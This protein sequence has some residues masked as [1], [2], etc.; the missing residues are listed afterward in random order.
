MKLLD[1]NQFVSK[2]NEQKEIEE[3]E[4]F[5][6]NEAFESKTIQKMV[7]N[8][9]G[10]IGKN[11]FDA[12]SK[13]GIAASEIKDSDIESITPDAATKYARANP[14]KL[15]IYYSEKAKDNPYAKD[16]W[17]GKI[18]ADVVLAV[19][20]GKLFMGLNY[21]NWASKK[22]SKAEYVLVA[23]G[24]QALGLSNKGNTTFSSGINTLDKMAAISDVVY[25]IDP[26]K[27]ASSRETRQERKESRQGATFFKDD[28]EFKRENLSRY[29]AIL[30]ERASKDDIDKI[31]KDSI[32]LLNAQ[33]HD[34]M[35][36]KETSEYG[37]LLVGT[38]PK[39]R[40]VKM[41][42]V[43]YHMN[44]ILKNYSDYVRSDNDAKKEKSEMGRD[45]YYASR[46]KE[47]AKEIKDAYNKIKTF[48]YA[49]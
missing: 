9:K 40:Q 25:V 6:I 7:N 17:Y 33:I 14:E 11:F 45:G 12:L 8:K 26:S 42:D 18:K 29:E 37:E 5:V 30:R 28:K 3:F 34:A 19:V 46:A 22:S 31:V 43:G 39:G 1:Y 4:N 47:L 23:G 2:L 24:S 36:K 10:Q 15:L 49:W 16:P 38:S 20:K 44:N 21:D 13:M 32:E 35:T 27:V 48:N 41:S